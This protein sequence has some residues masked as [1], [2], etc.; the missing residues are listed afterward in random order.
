VPTQDT[1]ATIS[2]YFCGE[3]GHYGEECTL[4]NRPHLA[5]ER[6]GDMQR[7]QQ[8]REAELARLALQR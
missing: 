7:A 3:E 4:E 6:A 5:A 8:E 2:C 1:V